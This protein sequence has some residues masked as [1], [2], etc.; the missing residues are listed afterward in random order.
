MNQD[1]IDKIGVSAAVTYFC[2]LG[3]INPHIVFDDK[4]AVWDGYLEIHK[5]KDSLSADDIDF[6]I[7]VQVKSSERDSNNFPPNEKQKIKVS[8][9]NHYK[10][11]GGTLLIKVLVGRSKCQLYF[12]YLGKLELNKILDT[13]EKEQGEKTINLDKA[14][15]EHLIVRHKLRSIYLQGKHNLLS[16]SQLESRSDY[17]LYIEAGPMHK[18]EN[19][20]LWMAANPV[21]ILVSLPEFDEP[22]YV[23]EGPSYINTSKV[24]NKPV[25][26][27]GTV[28]FTSFQITTQQ[29]GLDIKIG[30]FFSYSDCEPKDGK[31]VANLSIKP[32]SLSITTYIKELEFVLEFSKHKSF[33]LGGQNLSC[34]DIIINSKTIEVFEQRLNY[35]KLTVSLFEMLKLEPSFDIKKLSDNER[36]SLDILINCLLKNQTLEKGRLDMPIHRFSI[37]ECLIAVGVE[38]INDRL[39]LIDI[40]KCRAI[41]KHSDGTEHKIPLISYCLAHNCVA[42]NIY[43]DNIVDAYKVIYD[44]TKC[45]DFFTEVSFDVLALIK[46]YDNESK[47]KDIFLSKALELSNWLISNTKED[48]YDY[49]IHLINSLQCKYRMNEYFTDFEKER[50]NNLL[51]DNNLCLPAHILL[52]NKEDAIIAWNNLDDDNKALFKTFP[53]YN[54][55]LKLTAN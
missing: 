20:F 55:Y 37:G 21:D 46:F 49:N 16:A 18:K 9:L 40:N 42:D 29:H 5:S 7:D 50:L 27:N 32:N 8:D 39:R 26:I 41:K 25:E 44:E 33:T 47:H 10:N 23:K 34:P 45:Q 11:K 17:K 3:Y 6:T 52:G 14:P 38:E 36:E 4:V 35:C 31:K 54:L 1:R 15:N 24:I 43:C 53:I 19:P 13:C 51:Y 12:A 28:F 30:N 48:S 22:F 2:R